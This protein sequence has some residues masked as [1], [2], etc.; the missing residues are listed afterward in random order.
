MQCFGVQGFRVFKPHRSTRP[1]LLDWGL[2]REI[3]DEE[4]L[5]LAKAGL[6][7]RFRVWI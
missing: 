2:I 6:G 4:R 5:G 3:T 1:V 7:L